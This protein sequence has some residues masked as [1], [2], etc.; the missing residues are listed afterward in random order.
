MKKIC[1]IGHYNLYESKKVFCKGLADALSKKGM[2]VLYYEWPQKLAEAHILDDL[3]SFSPDLIASFNTFAPTSDGQYIWDLLDTPTLFMIVDPCLYYSK[4]PPSEKLHL[5]SVD[6]ND[7][8]ILKANGYKDVFFMPHAVTEEPLPEKEKTLDVVLTG[9][10]YDYESLKEF[11]QAQ[12]PP[13]QQKVLEEA[14]E[15]VL[16][17]GGISLMQAL[18]NAWNRHRLPPENADFMGLFYC[19]D[20]YTRG[21]DRVSLVRSFKNSRVHV[22]G[23]L[24]KDHASAKKGWSYYLKDMPNVALYSSL[25]YEAALEIQSRAKFCLNSMPF[26]KNGSHERI[27]TSLAA[28]S[29]PITSE[30]TWTLE[31]FLNEEELIVYV[32]GNYE[33][34]EEKVQRLL[35]DESER[36]AIADRGRAKVLTRHTWANRA[37][38][39]LAHF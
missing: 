37:E 25:H 38:L 29:V 35:N 39:F 14:A 20:Y 4:I 5:S 23:E 15:E 34:I 26:F 18:V 17:A 6:R 36:A 8:A 24:A 12:L 9:S 13:A 19:L 3:R 30:S 22:F 1:L 27:L 31:E 11:W 16:G 32:P 7:A 28:G 2:E 21:L 10:C 33:G